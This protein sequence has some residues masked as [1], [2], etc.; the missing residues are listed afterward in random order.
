MP[1]Q[2]L[3]PSPAPL[4][5]PS[6][7]QPRPSSRSERLLRETLRR[8]RAASISPRSRMPRAESR[9]GRVASTSS[10]MFHCACTDSDDEGDLVHDTSPHVS[11]LFTDLPQHQRQR[12]VLQHAPNGSADVLRH[13]S[14]L[15]EKEPVVPLCHSNAYRGAALQNP[16]ES[17]PYG[18]TVSQKRDRHADPS[19]RGRVRN[20]T[21]PPTTAPLPVR[22]RQTAQLPPRS[23]W[24]GQQVTPPP[25]PPTFDVRGAAAKLRT[26]D[27]YVSFANVEGL[28]GPP[29]REEEVMEDEARRGTWWPWRGRERSGSLG[30]T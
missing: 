27:G 30:T 26:I 23:H 22:P 19:T 24:Q 11:L 8:D 10:E 2:L 6:H 7:D 25:T 12:P 14:G 13:E 5:P 15:R 3:V 4:N 16:F 17:Y 1:P 9:S 20:N 18:P 28:G 29:G 21:H